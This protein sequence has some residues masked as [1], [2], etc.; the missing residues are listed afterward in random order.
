[1]ETA[2][3]RRRNVG[4]I[5]GSASNASIISNTNSSTTFDEGEQGGEA[6]NS[7]SLIENTASDSKSEADINDDIALKSS[8][9][10]GT[11]KN[12]EIT[13]D[14]GDQG[15]SSNLNDDVNIELVTL[16]ASDDTGSTSTSKEKNNN[17]N[18]IDNKTKRQ[19]ARN[20]TRKRTTS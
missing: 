10:I 18:N 19:R 8:P 17:S 2:T 9:S 6:N 4:K 5:R 16:F 1:M 20:R 7:K 14:E 15:G 3:A 12:T 13:T 11:D